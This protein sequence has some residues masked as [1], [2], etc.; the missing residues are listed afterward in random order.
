MLVGKDRLLVHL[1]GVNTSE[2]WGRSGWKV[3]IIFSVRVKGCINQGQNEGGRITMWINQ[4]NG[5]FF[6]RFGLRVLLLILF[7]VLLIVWIRF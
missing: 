1:F 4:K 6:S 3:Y 7:S 2:G 5:H